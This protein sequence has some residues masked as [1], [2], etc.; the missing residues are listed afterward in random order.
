MRKAPAAARVGSRVGGYFV[1]LGIH[2][3]HDLLDIDAIHHVNCD[4][5]GIDIDDVHFQHDNQLDEHHHD[6]P[7]GRL[8]LTRGNRR[9]TAGCLGSF[10]A[11]PIAP[12]VGAA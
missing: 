11:N 5:L 9:A 8:D 2:I 1:H 10:G 6:H 7:V 3:Q 4:H 12:G